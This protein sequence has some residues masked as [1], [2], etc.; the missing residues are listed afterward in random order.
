MFNGGPDEWAD[1]DFQF[2]ETGH[3]NRMVHDLVQ[4]LTDPD[5]N[6]SFVVDTHFLYKHRPLFQFTKRQ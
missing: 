1:A 6:V 3:P 2:F 5:P 4:R